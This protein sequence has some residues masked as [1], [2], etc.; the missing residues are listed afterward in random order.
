MAVQKRLTKQR[1]SRVVCRTKLA[2]TFNA[3]EPARLPLRALFAARIVTHAVGLWGVGG[4]KVFKPKHRIHAMVSDGKSCLCRSVVIRNE[5][6]F[7]SALR[8]RGASPLE[9]AERH[10]SK[11]WNNSRNNEIA[12][13]MQS[14]LHADPSRICRTQKRSPRHFLSP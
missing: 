14:K 11:N 2:V 13:D 8:K 3:W 7:S 1:V 9:V 6:Q 5:V 10:L 12:W 4:P